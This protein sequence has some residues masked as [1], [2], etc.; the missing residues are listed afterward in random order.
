LAAPKKTALVFDNC[1]RDW[2]NDQLGLFLKS[3][4]DV[5]RPEAPIRI[6]LG[7]QIVPAI[8]GV[9]IKDSQVSEL[10]LSGLNH[11]AANELW[12]AAKGKGVF[13]AVYLDSETF[14]RP[15]AL[16]LLARYA[17]K[18]SYAQALGQWVGSLVPALAD[19]PGDSPATVNVELI[20]LLALSALA[21]PLEI[22]YNRH[23]LTR[24]YPPGSL[25]KILPAFEPEELGREILIRAF[26]FFSGGQREALLKRIKIEDNYEKIERSLDWL[27]RDYSKDPE[28]AQLLLKLEQELDTAHPE[29]IYVAYIAADQLVDRTAMA[30]SLEDL[31]LALEEICLAVK[32][33]P[34]DRLI[35]LAEAQASVNAISHYGQAR[36]FLELEKWGNRLTSIVAAFPKDRE[37]GLLEAQA[38]FNAINQYGRAE[39]FPELENWGQ[40]LT[41]IIE[42][43]PEDREIG[44]REAQASVNAINHYG[45]AEKFLELEK[46][47]Q[48]LTRIVAAFP[49]DREIGLLEANAS[50][51]AIID[52][53]RAEK[54]PELENWGQR[55]TRIVAAFPED[56]EI[57]LREAKASFNAITDYGQAGEFTE[58]EKWGQRLT[59][60]VAAF[61]KD[62]EIGLLEAQASFNAINYYGR[63]GLSHQ[64]EGRIWR[65]RMAAIAWAFP[66]AEEIQ[67]LAERFGENHANQILRQMGSN[68]PK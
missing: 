68:I 42:A 37:I 60:I 15:R 8:I 31:A 17:G 11:Q 39:K 32:R 67:E 9:D 7:D 55:L 63:A 44:L 10:V 56:R 66:Q 19:Y 41:R 26:K 24:F 53:G 21:G 57:G 23:L 43:F 16:L 48:R 49:E 18:V 64:K 59:S 20:E 28:T 30:G 29:R 36:E 46:W 38:S 5:A 45:R 25:S 50:F 52:Y 61:P 62:R 2:K 3:L 4:L 13:D 35:R 6:L 22:E 12:Q 34:N 40:R 14:F 27:W 47:G 65:Q 54:F 58:L 1:A 51:N 33:R